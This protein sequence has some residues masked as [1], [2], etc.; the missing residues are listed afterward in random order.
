M[1][2]DWATM[3]LVSKGATIQQIPNMQYPPNVIFTQNG[4]LYGQP[5]EQLKPRVVELE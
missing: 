1:S 2:L 3:Q 4:L 5:N